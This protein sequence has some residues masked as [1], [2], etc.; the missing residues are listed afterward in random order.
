MFKIFSIEIWNLR[1]PTIIWLKIRF[2]VL[3]NPFIS[4]KLFDKQIIRL[5]NIKFLLKTR[6]IL[7]KRRIKEI[8]KVSCSW[9]NIK[10]D[11]NFF[12]NHLFLKWPTHSFLYLRLNCGN[13]LIL[14]LVWSILNWIKITILVGLIQ[15]WFINFFIDH[16]F[17]YNFFR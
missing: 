2:K 17:F 13:F 16:I 9:N 12:L 3:Y 15:K 5:W 11:L 14:I 1:Y 8:T 7:C 6:I 4:T 10:A